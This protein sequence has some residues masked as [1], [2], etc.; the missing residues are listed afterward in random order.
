MSAA[1]RH[2]DLTPETIRSALFAIDVNVSRDKWWRIAAALKTELGDAGFSMFDDWSRQGESY[3]AKNCKDTWKST[4]PGGGVGIATLIW[5]A[6][7]HG[8]E[9]DQDRPRLPSAEI[10]QRRAEREAERKATEAETRRVQGEAAKLANLTWEGADPAG[11]GHPYLQGKRVRAHGLGLGEW[12]LI[13]DR[14]EVFRRVPDALLLPIMD[15]KNGK[16]I[17]LQG[18]LVEPDGGIAKRYLKNG[19]KRGG[20]HMIGSPPGAGEP[21]AFAEGYATGATIHELT[22]WPVVVCFDAGNLVTVAEIMRE[23]FPQAAFLIC[24]DNDAWTKLGDIE[25]PGLHF[26]KRAA[27]ATR[28]FMLAPRFADVSSEPTDWNDLA[29]LEGDTVAREQLLANPVTGAAVP[30][31]D[32][33][34]KVPVPV[35]DNVDFFTPLP[36]VNGKGKPLATIENLAEVVDRLGMTVRYNVIAKNHEILIPGEGFSVDNR[37]NA[38]LA[39]LE[40]QC[41]KFGMP[42]EKLGGFLCYLGDQNPFNPVANWVTSSPW[43][44]VPRLQA[45]MDTVTPADDKKLPDGRSLKEVL[46]RRWMMSAIAGAFSPNGV[47]AH[48][49]LVF[50][51][52]QYLGKTM[53]FKQLAPADLGVLKDGL[54]LNPADRDSVKRVVSYWMVELGELDATFR[55]ADVAALKAFIPQDSD[56]LRLPYARK[57]SAFARRTVFFGSVNPRAFLHDPTGNRRYWTVEC[58]GLDLAAQAQLDMQQVWAEAYALWKA[59]EPHLLTFEE[60]AALNEHNEGFQAVDP[61][62]ERL[63]TRL[64]WQ[65][66]PMLWKWKTATEI[67]L[68]VGVDRPN[69]ADATK[70]AQMLRKLNGDQGKRSNGKTVLLV[71]PVIGGDRS[72]GYGGGEDR[73]F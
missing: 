25:N 43:D 45:L 8:W 1:E 47:S 30:A 55:K 11:D 23:K 35:N 21:L 41:A 71:P 22:G 29:Q 26:A 49:I 52:P 39:R 34:A 70:A 13:N 50:Q 28:G 17:S 63:Q 15:A 31:A 56:V 64:E 48:G 69:I 37:D 62:E 20:C 5:E 60:N 57:E 38:S 73:P 44:G 18:I 40:S 14:G 54:L 32:A 9:F 65:A 59:G 10:E 53:W 46:I 72:E 68:S 61:I 6:Q 51:G 24:A 19:R 2:D 3:D 58:A 36:D 66:L 67:L 12:P 27:D 4:K 33:P 16:V 42:T 7:Q